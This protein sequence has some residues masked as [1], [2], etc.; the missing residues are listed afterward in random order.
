MWARVAEAVAARAGREFRNNGGISGF[1]GI[2]IG[3][4]GESGINSQKS[5]NGPS[6][7][8]VVRSGRVP[9]GG[10]TAASMRNAHFIIIVVGRSACFAAVANISDNA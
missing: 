6:A 1:S 2:R 10:G 8:V 5:G 9:L 7:L 4:Y 3:K